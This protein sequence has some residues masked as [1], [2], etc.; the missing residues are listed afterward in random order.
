MGN[1]YPWADVEYKPEFGVDVST[2]PELRGFMTIDEITQKAISLGAMQKPQELAELLERVQ[3]IQPKT[4][5]E[6]GTAKGGTLYALCQVAADD[7]TIISLDLP[8]GQFGGGYSQD[9]ADK[10]GSYKKGN[11]RLEFIRDDSHRPVVRDA[12]SVLADGPLDVLVIDGD[13]T[14]EGVKKDWDM[15]SP[16]VREGG[17]IAFHDICYH[18]MVPDC[19]VDRFWNYLEGRYDSDRIIDPSDTTWG[20]I[21]IIRKG[22]VK[23]NHDSVLLDISKGP[24]QKGFTRLNW[25]LE[26]FPW[27]VDINSVQICV[28][29]HVIEHIKP[30]LIMSF[31]DE[32]W[33]ITKPGGQVALS[34]PYAGSMAWWSDPTHCT[35]F[36]ERSFAYLDPTQMAYATHRPKPWRIAKGNPTWNVN[37]NLE[38]LLFPVK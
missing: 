25:D 29:S 8:G 22:E 16:L 14:R 11:Q 37:G 2:Q 10:F 6:I 30:W 9:D 27:P 38:V 26:I 35:G 34:T 28:G 15:Y 18:P 5:L 12:V 32:L 13:H 24:V 3:G 23:L 21:G 31:F 20:G 4:I 17:L 1:Q 19:Q 7:A 36:N 33:R